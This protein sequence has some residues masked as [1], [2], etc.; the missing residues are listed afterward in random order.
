MSLLTFTEHFLWDI[1]CHFYS[2]SEIH[3]SAFFPRLLDHYYIKMICPD[4]GFY[5]QQ[6]LHVARPY[7]FSAAVVCAFAWCTWILRINEYNSKVITCMLISNF[8]ILTNIRHHLQVPVNPENKL[9]C[10]RTVSHYCI[11]FFVLVHSFYPEL[12]NLI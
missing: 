8:N 12:E 5:D 3:T 1:R 2:D 6:R 7:W 9:F 10:S 11:V 4:I